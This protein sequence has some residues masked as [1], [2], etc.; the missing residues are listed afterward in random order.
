MHLN[1]SIA[2]VNILHN[3]LSFSSFESRMNMSIEWKLFEIFTLCS[4][5]VFTCE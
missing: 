4:E 5:I 2:R 3:F 1:L